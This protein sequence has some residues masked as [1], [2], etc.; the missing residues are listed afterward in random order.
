MQNL[1]KYFVQLKRYGQ[2]HVFQ[3]LDLSTA[4]TDD[5]FMQF[6]VP[7]ASRVNINLY[8]KFYQTI[9]YGSIV[10][11]SFHL[12]TVWNS[13]K[14]RPTENSI[15]QSPGLDLVTANVYTKSLQ[16]IPYGSRD[17]ASFTFSEFGPWQ[18]LDR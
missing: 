13:A 10:M 11:D 5:K 1:S 8:A 2:F 18:N 17:R 9:P 15:W 7:S 6:A 12:F 3:N 16:N 4:S 14:S